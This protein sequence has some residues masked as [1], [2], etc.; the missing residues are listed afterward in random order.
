MLCLIRV[1]RF[2]VVLASLQNNQAIFVCLMY[3]AVKTNKRN[4]AKQKTH[5]MQNK[6][7]FCLGYVFLVQ[8]SEINQ[9]SL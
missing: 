8:D 1:I 3:K 6:S 5:P 4:D 7:D 2:L 9:N